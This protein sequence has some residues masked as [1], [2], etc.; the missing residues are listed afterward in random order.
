MEL[1]GIHNH[2]GT[3]WQDVKCTFP[4]S[5]VD[6]VDVKASFCPLWEFLT[7][8]YIIHS[9]AARAEKPQQQHQHKKE[10]V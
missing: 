6:G 8:P 5:C 3:I 2:S 9:V 1:S 10:C 7:G 4:S